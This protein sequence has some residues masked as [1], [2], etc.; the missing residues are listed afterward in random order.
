MSS[1]QDQLLKAGL[2]DDKKAKKAKQEKRKQ[3]KAAKQTGEDLNKETKDAA[4]K[5]REEKI[6]KDKALNKQRQEAQ[7]KKEIN[8]QIKQ[9]ISHHKQKKVDNPNSEANVEYN[10]TDGKLVKKIIVSPIVQKRLVAG[11]LAIAKLDAGYELIPR[12]IADK[13]MQRDDSFIVLANTK[14]AE[15]VDEDDPYK[16]YQIPDDLMW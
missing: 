10:F 2:I 3:K 14:S 15:D 5:A 1:L 7:Q 6:A 4:Q 13:I 11:T 8:A 12:V 9:L 16:D